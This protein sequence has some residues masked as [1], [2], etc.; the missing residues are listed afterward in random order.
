MV[1]YGT[2]SYAAPRFNNECIG[3]ASAEVDTVYL[4]CGHAVMCI[5]CATTQERTRHNKKCIQCNSGDDYI[6]LF[7]L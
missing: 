4:P 2:F 3:C 1:R 6:K 7:I 5:A